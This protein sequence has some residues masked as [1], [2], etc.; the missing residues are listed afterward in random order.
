MARED[1]QQI[2]GIHSLHGEC[3]QKTAPILQISNSRTS[4]LECFRPNY[5]SYHR[6]LQWRFISK[7]TE[8]TE[9]YQLTRISLW[10]RARSSC[11]SMSL[12]DLDNV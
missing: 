3:C 10:E 9:V 5:N 6:T 12:L 11:I 7:S 1:I 2:E 8:L 4:F